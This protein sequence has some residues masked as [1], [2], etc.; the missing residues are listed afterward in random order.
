M[1]R[2]DGVWRQQDSSIWTIPSG[3]DNRR[4][5]VMNSR[6]GSACR[7]CGWGDYY[8]ILLN[9][10]VKLYFPFNSLIS[11]PFGRRRRGK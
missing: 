10:W 11:F 6:H 5:G 2:R 1:G 4:G 3:S 8:Y 7:L 9:F